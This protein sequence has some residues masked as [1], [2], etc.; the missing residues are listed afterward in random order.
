MP[1]AKFHIVVNSNGVEEGHFFDGWSAGADVFLA[2]NKCRSIVLHG[3]Y[4][5]LSFLKPHSSFIEVLVLRNEV[6]V[7]TGLE[8]L[9][10]L[11]TLIVAMPTAEPIQFGALP[12]VEACELFW[13]AEYAR[14]LLSLAKLKS[15][16]VQRFGESSFASLVSTKSLVEL[17]LENPSIESFDGL[18]ACASLKRLHIANAPK[19]NDVSEVSE[20]KQLQYLFIENAKKVKSCSALGKVAA[21]VELNLINV[22]GMDNGLGATSFLYDLDRVNHVGITGIPIMIDWRKLLSLQI[23]EK[24]VLLVDG[25]EAPSDERLRAIVEENGKKILRT[26]RQ[27][28]KKT[29]LILLE[30]TKNK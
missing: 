26:V 23:L 11:K 9:R 29:P 22:G 24:V 14:S 10:N 30:L 27:G 20:L 25:K 18:K 21:L 6:E 1:K 13:H 28:T 17:R 2:E 19:L 12:K 5:D 3:A 15:L 7:A 8:V 4:P 16:T